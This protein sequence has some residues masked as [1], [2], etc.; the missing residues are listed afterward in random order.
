MGWLCRCPGIVLEPIRKRA[1]TQA[2]R[3]HSVTVISARWAT[4]EWSWPKGGISVRK[5]ISTFKKK[6]RRGMNCRIFSQNPLKR[7]RATTTTADSNVDIL[8]VD[9]VV[10]RY[11]NQIAIRAFVPCVP[12]VKWPFVGPRWFTFT[13]WGCWGSCLWHKPA[14]LVHS[15]L[16]CSCVCFCLCGPFNCISFHK[17]FDNSPLSHSVLP[18]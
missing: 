18:V 1:H 14:E 13:W 4:V 9:C 10:L 3:E 2:F 7:G 8:S 11:V 6:R 16:F 12:Q 15:F 5:L 17:F